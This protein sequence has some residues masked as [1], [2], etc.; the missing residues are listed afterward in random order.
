MSNKSDINRISLFVKRLEKI[1][2]KVELI[3]NFPWVYLDKVNGVKIEGSFRA[4]HGF[5]IGYYPDVWEDIECKR[6]I[7]D[8][9]RLIVN[10]RKYHERKIR[11][12]K[13]LG[14]C[15]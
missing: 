12:R 9:I 13:I 15:S 8:E 4:N 5:C 2:I 7:F 14:R 6:T 1:G 3:G 10:E 11:R